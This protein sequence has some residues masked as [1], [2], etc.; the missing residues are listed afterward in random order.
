M[1]AVSEQW[2][3]LRRACVCAAAAVSL[4]CVVFLLC[5]VFECDV[6][7]VFVRLSCHHP[8]LWWTAALGGNIDGFAF[9]AMRPA[10]LVSLYICSDKPCSMKPTC[11]Y[12]C[13]LI[14]VS[15]VCCAP[16]NLSVYLSICLSVYLSVCLSIC[17]SACFL[18]SVVRSLAGC[19]LCLSFR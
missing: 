17:L 19:H 13:W 16:C 11:V 1:D 8:F 10:G 15:A 18:T 5:L 2:L 7:N 9:D 3:R 12:L 4:R 6:C 14:Y